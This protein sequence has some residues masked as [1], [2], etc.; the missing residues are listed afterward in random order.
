MSGQAI[1]ENFK[2]GRGGEGLAEAATLIR[3]ASLMYEQHALD[4]RQLTS[5]MES[6]WQGD[7]A[8][9]AQRGA[10]PLAVEHEL[11]Q[12]ELSTVDDLSNRQVGSYNDAKNRVQPIPD[13][14]E[15]PS[16]WDNITSFG[17]ASDTYEQQV[18]AN[19]N[20]N[21]NNVQVMQAYESASLYN[22]DNMP[23]TYGQMQPDNSQIVIGGDKGG[24]DGTGDGDGDDGRQQVT[25][26]PGSSGTTQPPSGTTQPP[27]NPSGYDPTNPSG[28]QPPPGATSS[29]SRRPRRRRTRRV[30]PIRRVGLTRPG[31][32]PA[33]WAVPAGDAAAGER[34]DRAGWQAA[35]D[36][37]WASAGW[38]AGRWARWWSGWASAGWR[39]SVRARWRVERAARRAWRVRVRAGRRDG[40]GG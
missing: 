33:W 9:A 37:G 15:E 19:R 12:P 25:R 27:T 2:N 31:A 36:A 23:K 22:G 29:R 35:G 18:Q 17:G 39:W 1:Y 28:W 38:R 30:G 5:K 4:I 24:D 16:L 20:A 21:D 40:H 7:A 34:A 3:E 32:V 6:Y 14:P 13:V 26:P 11:A 10:G 8:G